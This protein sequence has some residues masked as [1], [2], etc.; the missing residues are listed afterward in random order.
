[1]K[2]ITPPLG[3]A[4][5]PL[6]GFQALA[7][8]NEFGTFANLPECQ[9]LLADL[10]NVLMRCAEHCA[11]Q[12]LKREE[13]AGLLLFLAAHNN[14]RASVR[15]VAAGQCLPTYATGRA[16]L[17][18][19][20]YGWYFLHSHGAA[21]RWHQKPPDKEKRREW[22]KEFQFSAI[23]RE[24][25]KRQPNT[26]RAGRYLHQLAIDFGGH[27]NDKA[28]YSNMAMVDRE[29]GGKEIQMRYLH[30][31]GFLFAGT[32]KFLVEVGLCI[33][34]L[35]RHADAQAVDILGLEGTFHRLVGRLDALRPKLEA[36]TRS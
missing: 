30:T 12:V 32:I 27:P 8:S 29:D 18:Y 20:L 34:D 22:A 4:D 9:Q 11:N 10:D 3:W 35:C 17:E 2:Q 13:P 1:M 21:Q 16:A 31:W 23:V 24:L 7:Q 15:L 36:A 25:D 33:V 14:F 19:A 5:D 26:A 6:S 28:L